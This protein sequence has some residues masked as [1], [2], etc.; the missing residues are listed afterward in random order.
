M[1]EIRAVVAGLVVVVLIAM[2]YSCWQRPAKE[3]HKISGY[4][5]EVQKTEGDSRKHV[6]FSIPIVT[7]ARIASMIPMSNV[8]A[9]WDS[10]WGRGEITGK[11]ILD[12]ASQSA[13]GKPGV[14]EK[15]DNKIEVMA[16]GLALDITIKD[17]WDK[18]V[19]VRVPRVLVESLADRKRLSVREVLKKLDELG[20]GDVVKIEDGDNSV[21]ISAEAK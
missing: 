17:S 4:R 6:S 12:A 10:D 9:N 2:A 8:G 16:D 7:V 3:F 20:P 14:I 5:V 15:D 19:R 11:D 13:P 1:R 21:T 18:T